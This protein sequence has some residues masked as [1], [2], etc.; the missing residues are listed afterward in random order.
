M[1][2]STTSATS[3]KPTGNRKTYNDAFR[4]K[5]ALAAFLFLMI[6]VTVPGQTWDIGDNVKASLNNGMLTISGIG[7]MDDLFPNAWPWPKSVIRVIIIKNGVINI[8]TNAFSGCKNLKSVTIPNSVKEIGSY[9]FSSCTGLKSITIP[10]SVTMIGSTAFFGCTG[11]SSVVIPNSVTEIGSSAFSGC[12][13]LASVTIPNSVTMIEEFTFFGC[14][15][16]KSVTIPNGVA[17]IEDNA[18]S[19]TG[20]R[21]ITIPS[22]VKRIDS[23]HFG[24]PFNQCVGLTSI[25]AAIDNTNYS[26]E[27]G[28]LYN[29][30]KTK[31]IS[32][33]TGKRGAYTIPNGVTK[34]ASY[35]FIYCSG[36]TSVIIPNS[37]TD[38]EQF[39]FGECVGLTAVT[40]LNISPPNFGGC[41]FRDI[42]AGACLY[43]HKNS[44]AAY[45]SA[46]SV[47]ARS[48]MAGAAWFECIKAIDTDIEQAPVDMIR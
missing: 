30:D 28:V 35:A 23:Y 37:V 18:F 9:A 19:N 48:C 5:A 42:P 11:L 26:S 31:L 14:T 10:N 21:S 12:T 1:R 45:R 4:A 43:A 36:L 3:V 15:G 6:P 7:K 27:N 32:Y 41:V 46:L 25:N 44:I 2:K 17:V 22:S 29:K 20:L 16:L 38:I 24:G 13:G 8:G 40:I 33:P 47:V 34:I 39:A